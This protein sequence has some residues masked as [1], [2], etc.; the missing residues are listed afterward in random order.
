MN[1]SECFANVINWEYFSAHLKVAFGQGLYRQQKNPAV[2][3]TSGVRGLF[4]DFSHRCVTVTSAP[5]KA[6]FKIR[7][8]LEIVHSFAN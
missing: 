3:Q 4:G 8:K 1:E 2:E 5:G 6:R 7:T